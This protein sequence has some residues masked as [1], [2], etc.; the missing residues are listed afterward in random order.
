MEYDFEKRYNE[1]IREVQEI[2]EHTKLS[3]RRCDI[4][5][6]LLQ[7]ALAEDLFQTGLTHWFSWI[8]LP[9]E[10]RR[11]VA[12]GRDKLRQMLNDTR[13]EV[14]RILKEQCHC[15]VTGG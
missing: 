13:S 9:E 14:A 5:K 6:T 15:K 12:E 7:Y 1:W 3:A 4:R 8:E 11:K 10:Q 2:I